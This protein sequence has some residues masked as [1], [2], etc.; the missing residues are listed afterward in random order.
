MGL[1]DLVW[2]GFLC[3]FLLNVSMYPIGK[4]I[5]REVMFSF[6]GNRLRLGINSLVPN[7]VS[8]VEKPPLEKE[9]GRRPAKPPG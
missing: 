5:L 2:L 4:L 8:L 9:E 3:F 7:L 1:F 6:R